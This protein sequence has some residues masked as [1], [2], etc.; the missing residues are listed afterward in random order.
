MFSF[1]KTKAADF[2]VGISNDNNFKS[3]KYK[4]KILGNTVA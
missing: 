3:F 4:A 1:S 2:N